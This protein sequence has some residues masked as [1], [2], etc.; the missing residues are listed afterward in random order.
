M[1]IKKT[2]AAILVESHKP[3]V[4]DEISLP[5][6]LSFG[7][8]L[9][10]LSYSGI[11]GAQLNEID[12]AKGPDK[13]LP[14]LLG[15]E[16]SGRVLEIGEGVKTVKPGDHVV[17]HWRP[18][19]GLQAEPPKYGWGDKIVNAGWVTTFNQHAIVSENRLTTIPEKFDMK[20]APLF[21]CAV[22]TALGV[23]NND[24]Q[25]K[26]GQSVVVFG[27]GGVGLSICQ[28]ASL[29]SANPIIAI[30]VNDAKTSR[31]LQWGATHSINSK[32]TPDIESELKKILGDEKPDVII[33]TTGNNKVIEQA[34][35]LTHPDGKT[36][37]VGVPR[38]DQ[39]VNIYTLPLH[40]NQILKGSHGGSVY[41]DKE[42]PRLIR[43]SEQG[44]LK[45]AGLVTHEFPFEEI[46][47]AIATVRTGEAGR[48]VLRM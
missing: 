32:T 45:L 5:E 10:E 20:L 30:D 46:N 14:H 43:L 8:V 35:G 31:V 40:F 3:L 1:Q 48:V 21:G 41:P 4:V 37:L 34:Y 22:T 44:K 29:V 24:A 15:H 33:D 42:I 11:C 36:I 18:S 7:Q 6:R 47:S 27:A 16:G 13:F 28:M 23:V 17:L 25:I 38:K 2:K 39:N 26:V 9:V 12:A 19:A